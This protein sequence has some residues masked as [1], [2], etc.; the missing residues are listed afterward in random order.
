VLP[1]EFMSYVLTFQP[2]KNYNIL[3]LIIQ[4]INKTNLLMATNELGTQQTENTLSIL[5]T[6]ENFIKQIMH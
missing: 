2:R 3:V 6:Q 1:Q 4:L 5:K